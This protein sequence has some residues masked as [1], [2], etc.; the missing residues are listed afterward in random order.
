MF[1][2]KSFIAVCSGVLFAAVSAAQTT[3]TPASSATPAAG[4]AAQTAQAGGVPTFVRPET[5]AE[6]QARLATPEDPGTD[7]DPK[8]HFWRFGKSYHIEKFER[9]WAKYDQP[10]GFVRPWGF[11]AAV[12]EIYQQNERYVWVWAPDELKPQTP[13]PEVAADPYNEGVY[14]FLARVRPQFTA[15][16][17]PASSTAV[18]FRESSAGLP[19]TGSWRNSGSVA[20]MNG[21]KCPDLVAP[22]ERKGNGLPAIFLGDCKGGWRLWN[23]VQFPSR[24]DYGAAVVA[25]FNK[26]NNMD[27]AFAVH[28]NGIHVWL[29][30]GKGKFKDASAGMPRDF[31]TRRLVAVDVDRDGFTDI[32]ASNEGPTAI[33]NFGGAPVRAF[34]NRNRASEWQQVEIAPADIKVGGDWLSVGNLNGDSY[35]DVVVASVYFGTWDVVYLSSGK[36]K[37][38]TVVSDG[39]LLPSQSYYFANATGKFTSRTR[40]D[41][42][43]SYIRFWPPNVNP[44]RVAPPMLSDVVNI[45]R[46]SFEKGKMRRH[47]IARWAGGQVLGLAVG[48]FNG[49]RNLDIIYAADK[50]REA[51][52]LLGDGRGGFSSATVSGLRVLD[53][54]IYDV[55]VADVN[56]DGKPDVILMY[57]TAGKSLVDSNGSIR[58][59]LND[60]AGP[61]Q[62]LAT[63]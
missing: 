18:R 20:D 27:L 2:Q 46:L 56:T 41:A 3:E 6:R 49:D 58:V 43:I 57:E 38:S 28:L 15:L 45:D 39:D 25:D 34:I 10:E 59:Y 63:K 14:S 21:D 62:S 5:P 47:S 37:W 31:P 1:N 35:P 30:D 22:P 60:G 50:P 33:E 11:A 42:I 51:R 16:T 55:K 44:Q 36:K 9:V 8:K 12:F 29:G 17:P 19:A 26:D 54:P 24:L 48:D 32:V 7:P 53:N 61:A 13:L 23:D 40:D 4:V 52:I